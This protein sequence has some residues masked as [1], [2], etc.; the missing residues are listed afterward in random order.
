MSD[1]LYRS[2]T[3]AIINNDINEYEKYK[4]Q[5]LRAVQNKKVEE[6]IDDLQK[7]ISEIKILLKQI[8]SRLN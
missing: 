5:R 2:Q 6:K 8:H 3:G 4:M 7:D 1:K